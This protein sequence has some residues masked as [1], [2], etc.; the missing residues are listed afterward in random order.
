[1]P[2]PY[3]SGR[4]NLMAQGQLDLKAL[5]GEVPL[6]GGGMVFGAGNESL[7]LEQQFTSLK[8]DIK[9]LQTA[10]SWS[11]GAP[12]TNYQRRRRWTRAPERDGGWCW[13]GAPGSHRASWAA[14]RPAGIAMDKV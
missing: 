9:T 5:A 10:P 13:P 14:G 3:N 7:D 11:Q 8:E 12:A 2:R 4:P 6:S 1:M